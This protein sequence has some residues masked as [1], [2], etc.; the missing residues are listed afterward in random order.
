MALLLSLSFLQPAWQFLRPSGV[1]GAVSP[2]AVPLAFLP[3][4]DKNTFLVHIHLPDA[5]PLEITDQAAREVGELLRRQPKVV[6]Y[7]TFVGRTAVI[8]FNGQR[9]GSG[10]L[11]GPGEEVGVVTNRAFFL[12]TLTLS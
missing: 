11:V 5:T 6:D 4:D 3:K 12:S 1:A 7:Q 10:R 8:D 2:L 9:K